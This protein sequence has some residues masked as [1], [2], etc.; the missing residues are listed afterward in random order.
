MGMIF[1]V[2]CGQIFGLGKFLAY[3]YLMTG[4]AA[5]V[6]I[7]KSFLINNREKPQ[8][9]ELDPDREEEDDPVV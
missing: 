9:R 5:L 6:C 2:V 4:V 8:A 1:F 3:I 7:V